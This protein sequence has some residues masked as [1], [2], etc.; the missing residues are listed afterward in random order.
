MK[1]IK[2]EK[3]I[4]FGFRG[5]WGKVYKQYSFL[6]KKGGKILNWQKTE[7]YDIGMDVQFKPVDDGV[8]KQKMPSQPKENIVGRGEYRIVQTTDAY[9]NDESGEFEC[10]VDLGD[11]VEVFGSFWVVDSIDESCIYTP[12]KHS[13]YDVALKIIRDKI[14]R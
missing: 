7:Y 8:A 12:A 9:F 4:P 10:V 3:R 5:D 6:D 14:L 11:I 2:V 1:N 13:F